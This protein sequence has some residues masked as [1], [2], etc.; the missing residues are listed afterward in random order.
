MKNLQKYTQGMPAELAASYA[1]KIE[2]VAKAVGKL[3][4]ADKAA[5]ELHM[6]YLV[7]QVRAFADTFG[8]IVVEGVHDEQAMAEAKK[9]AAQVGKAKAE[10]GRV[11]DRL[12]RGALDYGAA[13]QAVHNFL[14]D[15]LQELQDDL[16]EKAN[17][18][19]IVEE[20][21]AKAEAEKRMAM[22][23]E[24]DPDTENMSRHYQLALDMSGE[25]WDRYTEGVLSAYHKK[26]ADAKAEAEKAAKEAAELEALRKQKA[27]F[28]RAEAQKKVMAEREAALKKKAEELEK[29]EEQSRKKAAARTAFGPEIWARMPDM[30][31]AKALA[32]KP[33]E[34]PE[35]AEK[36]RKW[37]RRVD[38]AKARPTPDMSDF[39]A[40][41]AKMR[42]AQRAFP[43][44]AKTAKLE[45][46]FDEE[47]TKIM[48][49]HEA[50]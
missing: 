42:T 35:M 32:A 19:A 24:L 41:A 2:R 46:E 44:K 21:A 4:E 17:Y 34:W 7:G 6:G 29:I 13:V 5:I 9:A 1:G 18:K 14:K 25:E 27:A 30:A 43:G 3:S 28:E 23:A 48:E 39:L 50:S 10:V 11:K 15:E 49:H 26:V 36:A 8:G 16:K 22:L 37:L 33:S 12:K 38:A 20:K 47:L 45:K 40:L 31:I